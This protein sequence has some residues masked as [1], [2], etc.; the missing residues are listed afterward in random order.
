MGESRQQKHTQHA[1]SMKM[2][3]DYLTGW[4]KKNKMF[5]IVHNAFRDMQHARMRR[6]RC[7][8]GRGEGGADGEGERKRVGVGGG[9]D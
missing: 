8:V 7:R 3:C 6:M 9:G 2:E 4:I 1:P 5:L